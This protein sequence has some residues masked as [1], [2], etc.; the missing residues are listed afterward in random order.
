[1]LCIAYSPIPSWVR[2]PKKK[3]SKKL[4]KE[5]KKEKKI[6]KKKKTK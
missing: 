3:L 4:K 5:N 6:T 1:M 2:G